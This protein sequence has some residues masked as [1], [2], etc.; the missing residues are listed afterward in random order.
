MIWFIIHRHNQYYDRYFFVVSGNTNKLMDGLL[1]VDGA[2]VPRPV[3]CNPSLT[4]SMLA[5]RCVRLLAARE[6]WTIDYDTVKPLGKT[7][8]PN[9]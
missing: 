8:T 1:V 5:E 6:N 3:G 7:Y 2:I 9:L 4:I